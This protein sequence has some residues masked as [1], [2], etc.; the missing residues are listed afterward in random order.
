MK[1]LMKTLAFAPGHI[2]GFFE[3]VYHAED[4]SR[5]GSR[6]AG[7]SISLGAYSESS[8]INTKSQTIEV[9]INGRKSPAPVTKLALNYLVG[10]NSLG[11]TIK[12]RLDLPMGQGFGMSAAGALSACLAVSKLCNL[13]ES[14]ALRAAHFA[15]VRLGTGLGDVISSFFGGFEIRK[16]PGLPPWGV[17]EHIHGCEDIVLCV[18]GKKINTKK[19][20]SDKNK[21]S[22][23]VE[24]G[25]FCTKKILEKPTVDNLFYL[26]EV[27]TN[28]TGLGSKPVV[29]AI[30]AANKFGMSSMCMLGNSLFAIGNKEEL[31]KTLSKY[32][33]VYIASVDSA[34]SRIIK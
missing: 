5:C 34:G 24:Y 16:S 21:V 17:I 32:G 33:R 8:V 31:I 19:I 14:D 1:T 25:R 29:D 18:I 2:T 6:G 13:S 20:L 30:N 28:K 10:N 26:S 23:I 11:I 22:K 3:P 15:E 4:M 27:F 9:F 12:T 7:V